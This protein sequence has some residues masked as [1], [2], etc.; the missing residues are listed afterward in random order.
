MTINE[1][2]AGRTLYLF[3]NVES[4]YVW[5]TQAYHDPSIIDSIPD[6]EHIVV[7]PNEFVEAEWRGCEFAYDGQNHLRIDT[8]RLAKGS[9]PKNAAG[10]LVTIHY[11]WSVDC[12]IPFREYKDADISVQLLKQPDNQH[13]DLSA[14]F[15]DNNIA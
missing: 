8:V 3:N 11:G 14:L 12:I 1:G 13:V 7:L 15:D 5:A 6:V 9:Q 2:S 4:A 10:V